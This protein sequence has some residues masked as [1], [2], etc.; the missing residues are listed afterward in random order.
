M[1]WKTQ[2]E[3]AHIR[4]EMTASLPPQVRQ[5]VSYESADISQARNSVIAW[6]IAIFL[7]R[8]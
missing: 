1:P 6:T 7:S 3:Q 2:G 5:V 8:T 4:L